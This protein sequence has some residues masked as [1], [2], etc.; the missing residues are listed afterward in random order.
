MKKKSKLTPLTTHNEN[1]SLS[2]VPEI[3]LFRSYYFRY[4]PFAIENISQTFTTNVGFGLESSAVLTSIGDLINKTY[5]EITLPEI[6][7]KRITSTTNVDAYKTSLDNLIKIKKFSAINR[8]AFISL[9]NLFVA[10]NIINP[11]YIVDSVNNVFNNVSNTIIIQDFKTVIASRNTYLYSEISL[12]DIVNNIEVDNTPKLVFYN[13]AIYGMDKMIAIQKLFFDEMNAFKLLVEDDANENIKFAWVENVGHAIIKNIEILIN[14]KTIDKHTGTWMQIK[15]ELSGEINKQKLRDKLL[16][17]IPELTDFNRKTKPQYK[18]MI[19]LHFWFC[20]NY[21]SSLPILAFKSNQIIIK[22]EFRKIEEVS[23]I[24]QDKL[25]YR[26]VGKDSIML[27]DAP[28]ILKINID[29]KLLVDYIYLS[30]KERVKFITNKYEYIIDTIQQLT[31]SENIN[32]KL[33]ISL[34]Q[35]TGVN[36]AFVWIA[37]KKSQLSNTTGFNKTNFVKFSKNN[38]SGSPIKYSSIIFDNFFRVPRFEFQYFNYVVPMESYMSTPSDGVNIFCFSFNSISTQSNGHCV[39]GNNI[40]RTLLNIEFDSE[41][42]DITK[43]K[44]AEK[45]TITL[46]ARKVNI[47]RIKNGFQSLT[48]N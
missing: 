44:L 1:I 24:E 16:G 11:Q 36:S 21:N 31:I 38:I 33:N 9:N 18:L 14:G 46:Y 42:L 37:Q 17:N 10:V 41:L 39:I 25:I 32:P 30:D 22:V 27:K 3:T 28:E 47:L 29:S 6:A 23:Y 19:P 48:F 13:N 26:G 15:T 34:T 45:Y 12:Q 8:N 5:L 40:K 43:L 4:E 20:N 2:D 7:F 35:F